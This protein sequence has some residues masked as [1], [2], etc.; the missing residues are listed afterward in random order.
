MT[1]WGIVFN[2]FEDLEGDYIDYV[3][4]QMGHD[5]IWAF[6]PLLPDKEEHD[7]KGSIGRGGTSVVPPDDF[8]MC[9]S[10]F[11]PSGFK[12]QVE[13]RG[14]IFKG[15]ASQLEIL[16]HKAIGLFITHYGWNS[17]LEAVTSGVMMLTW[18]TGADQF[19]NAALV[20]DQLGVGKRV[21][22]GGL[23]SVPDSV[24]G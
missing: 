24:V 7:P 11:I 15:W 3:K 4:K 10:T 19:T 9:G 21:C 5:R 18:P 6:G 17:T 1:S 23:R 12:D 14:F 16:R 22:D 20:V 2:T 13:G 8:F